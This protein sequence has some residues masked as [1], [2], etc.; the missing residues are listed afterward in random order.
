MKLK[1]FAIMACTLEPALSA[2]HL[3]KFTLMD[4]TIDKIEFHIALG[5][6]QCLSPFPF[7]GNSQAHMCSPIGRASHLT[8][9]PE[10]T[11]GAMAAVV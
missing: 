5:L 10:A 4:Q 7:V 2:T 3:A 9:R 8:R 6:H 11:C 1:R